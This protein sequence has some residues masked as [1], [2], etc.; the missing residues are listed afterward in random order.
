MEL[1][2]NARVFDNAFCALLLFAVAASAAAGVSV[3]TYSTLKYNEESGDLNGFEIMIVRIDGGLAATVQ[4]AKDGINELHLAK[5]KESGGTMRFSVLPDGGSPID[6][7]MNCT[8]KIC[9][10]EYTWGYAKKK[11]TLLKSNGY[12]NKKRSP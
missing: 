12:W 3:G 10:G 2:M 11:I 4:I 9:S 8:P 7:S 6:F 1:Q 5:V